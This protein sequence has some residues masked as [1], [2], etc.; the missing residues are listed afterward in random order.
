[1]KTK[2]TYKFIKFII[3]CSVEIVRDHSFDFIKVLGNQMTGKVK[4]ARRLVTNL[5]LAAEVV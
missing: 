3:L 5:V 2:S 4:L 1:M